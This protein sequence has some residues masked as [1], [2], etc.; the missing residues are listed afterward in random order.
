[1]PIVKDKDPWWA[2]FKV[3]VFLLLAISIYS[4]VSIPDN[5]TKK[6]SKNAIHVS[7]Q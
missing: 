1:M 7:P 2:V 4:V 5:K 3:L 6:E